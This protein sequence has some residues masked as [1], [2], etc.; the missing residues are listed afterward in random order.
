MTYRILKIIFQ[1]V[2]EDY[3]ETKPHKYYLLEKIAFLQSKFH[4]NTWPITLQISVIS[5]SDILVYLLMDPSS[6]FMLEN[7]L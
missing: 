3:D 6:C 7:Y 1:Y 5:C 4:I 2:N